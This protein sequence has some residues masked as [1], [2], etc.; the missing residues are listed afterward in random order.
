MVSQWE[1]LTPWYD[2]INTDAV[3]HEIGGE[4]LHDMCGR[5]F[6]LPIGVS[7]SR[8]A[9]ETSDAACDDDLALLL[10]VACPLE[11]Q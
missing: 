10:N 7:S 11:R 2:R 1:R 5:S 3:G 8:R 4:H 9:I 6:G